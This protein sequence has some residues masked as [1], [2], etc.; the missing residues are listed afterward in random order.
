MSIKMYPNEADQRTAFNPSSLHGGRFVLIDALRGIAALGVLLHHLLHCT[1]LE[2][3]LREILPQMVLKMSDLGAD[4]VEVFFVLSGFVIAHSVGIAGMNGSD[5]GRFALRRQV[6]LDPIYWIVT[7]VAFG[8][9]LLESQVLDLPGPPFP[10]VFAV[11]LN[12]LY[13]HNI[14]GA[15]PVLDV[16]WTLCI[17]IQFYLIFVLVVWSVTS[18]RRSGL[19]DLRPLLVSTMLVSGAAS[20]FFRVSEWS[21]S[22]VWFFPYWCFF[23]AGVLVDW[24][25]KEWISWRPA[26]VMLATLAAGALHLGDS[27]TFVGLLACLLIAGVG[28]AGRLQ[29]WSGGSFLQYF[30]RISYSLYLVHLPVLS[31]VMRGGYKVTGMQPWAAVGW[32]LLAAAF[33]VLFA[34]L[35]YRLVERPTMMFTRR[36]RKISPAVMATRVSGVTKPV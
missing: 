36:I 16:A 6:R 3:A 4:G 8:A 18:L 5:V 12:G 14:V 11:L 27:E 30:G 28:I 7:L 32:F 25:L 24:S 2:P 26:S 35:L 10:S 23:A 9:A 17:E 20:V 34:D 19:G 29:D 22:N 31:L 1:V 15:T 13:L 21:G 33:S